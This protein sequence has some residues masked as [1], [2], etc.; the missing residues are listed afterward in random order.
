[1]KNRTGWIPRHRRGGAYSPWIPS[2]KDLSVL[3]KCR[4]M[5]T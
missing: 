3:L 1:M 5:A 2:Y 4:N